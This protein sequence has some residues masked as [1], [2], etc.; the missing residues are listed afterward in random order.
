MKEFQNRAQF[1]SILD[2]VHRRTA[3]ETLT[4]L[5]FEPASDSWGAIEG[6]L[7]QL[8]LTDEVPD[9]STVK[10]SGDH[11]FGP[12]TELPDCYLI[13]SLPAM[14]LTETDGL[15]LDVAG[16]RIEIGSGANDDPQA[17]LFVL[18]DVPPY[19]IH[20]S[21]INYVRPQ[22]GPSPDEG[23]IREAVEQ[24]FGGEAIDFLGEGVVG[25]IIIAL[26]QDGTS[27]PPRGI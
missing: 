20:N 6:T 16:R 1:R 10:Y 3:Y 19:A 15:H 12:V 11:H 13:E 17:T 5:G 8:P 9:I 22:I 25:A 18:R 14:G 23:D 4:G 26:Q 2:G 24:S 21:D 7:D 27:N